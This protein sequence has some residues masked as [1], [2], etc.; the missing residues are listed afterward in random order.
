[1][2]RN[3]TTREWSLMAL[4]SLMERGELADWREFARALKGNEQLARDALRVS[5]YVEDR[6]S[7]SLIR[8]LVSQRFPGLS[9]GGERA[10]P[11][12]NQ[13]LAPIHEEFR[14]SGMSEAELSCLI[15]EAR[16]EVWQ[17]KQRG[18]AAS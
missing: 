6:A 5:D 4:E 1:M 7:A 10:L 14:Q 3:L 12:L 9:P 11:S 13:I 8:V 15:E 16:D 17:E 18:K 2:H